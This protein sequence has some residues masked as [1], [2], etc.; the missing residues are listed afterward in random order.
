MPKKNQ[1]RWIALAGVVFVGVLVYV[2]LQQ[3][4]HEYEV[5]MTFKGQS[6]CATAKGATPE[7][8]IRSAQEIDCGLIAD[9]RDANI[10]CL[11]TQPASVREIK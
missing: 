7:Q 2:T 3:S 1:N 5:C 9:G 10:V 4:Q 8:A 6:H 11:D